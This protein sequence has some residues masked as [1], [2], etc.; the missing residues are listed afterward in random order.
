MQN[1]AAT[2]I[3]KFN[4][5]KRANKNIEAFL[6]VPVIWKGFSKWFINR[7]LVPHTTGQIWAYFLFAGCADWA[8]LVFCIYL[9]L[10][11]CD[12]SLSNLGDLALVYVC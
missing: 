9:F 2:N 5:K 6:G 11:G 3:I 4:L 8:T 1:V 10:E 12:P 7:L